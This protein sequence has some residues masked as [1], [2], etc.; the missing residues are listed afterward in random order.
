MREIIGAWTLVV[1][2]ATSVT[3][4]QWYARGEFNNWEAT[5][6]MDDQ[7][8]GYYTKTISGLTPGQ[9]YEYK[10]ALADFADAAPQSN[11]L[12]GADGSGEINYHFWENVTWS[13]GWQ[14]SASKRVG[15]EDHGLFGWELVGEMN[16][17]VGGASW[18]LIDQGD[19]LHSG[20]FPLNTGSHEWKF[21]QQGDWTYGIGED[22]GNAAFN[23]EISVATNGNIWAFDLDLPNG[24][25]RAYPVPEPTTL[26][27]FALGGIGLMCCRRRN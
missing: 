10:I 4:T 23:S 16:N 27:M 7:G 24:R 9:A 21:R 14:P 6:L 3:A 1:L 26:M 11:G 5:D 20:Q 2:T 15:Y 8:G 17:W 22:F 25:W 13:D 19:G 12:V 18:Y